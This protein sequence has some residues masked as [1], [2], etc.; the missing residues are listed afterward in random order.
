MGIFADPVAPATYIP[1]PSRARARIVMQHTINLLMCAERDL[2]NHVFTP[3]ALFP[4][5]VQH[6]PTHF[7][8]FACP[9]VHPITGKTISS[10]KRLMRD[11]ATAK[12]WQTAFGQDFGGM[13][14]G[15]NR[16]G[17]KGTNTMF[18]M[19]LNEIN[20][21]LRQGKKIMY[22]NLVVDYR[23]PKDEPNCIRIT[24]RGNLVKYEL[25]SSVRTA[26]LDIAKL[27]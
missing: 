17:Q 13:A 24:A 15:D 22:G 5:A 26:Y 14:Q 21:V 19:T 18:V 20:Q 9:M 3:T 16:T 12:T 11:P 8:H 10:Y 23:P 1:I 27:H 7:E 25:S 6:Y 4:S 2:C